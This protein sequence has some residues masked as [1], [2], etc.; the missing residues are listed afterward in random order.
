M[1]GNLTAYYNRQRNYEEEFLD[2]SLDSQCLQ[3]GLRFRLTWGHRLELKHL[4]VLFTEGHTLGLG[5]L[6]TCL[7]YIHTFRYGTL[8]I[9]CLGT[10]PL[11]FPRP[12]GSCL[13][14]VPGSA[15]DQSHDLMSAR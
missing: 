13:I 4:T 8:E 15:R 7:C 1:L 14:S 2:F 11:I 6:H 10:I 5:C 3:V 12:P 9:T